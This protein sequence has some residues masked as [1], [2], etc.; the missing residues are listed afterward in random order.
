MDD[1]RCDESV[2]PTAG[3]RQTWLFVDEEVTAVIPTP[4]PDPAVDITQLNI[5]TK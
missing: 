2:D 4:G 5:P 3:E 1:E